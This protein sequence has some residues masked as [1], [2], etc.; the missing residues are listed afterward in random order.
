MRLQGRRLREVAE[1]EY[2]GT[3]SNYQG[4]SFRA[5]TLAFFFA[6]SVLSVEREEEGN[7]WLRQHEDRVS[8]HGFLVALVRAHRCEADKENGVD[9]KRKRKRKR[10]LQSGFNETSW[11]SVKPVSRVL[12][13]RHV[14]SPLSCEELA[15]EG[16]A[17]RSVDLRLSL[18]LII[19]SFALTVMH[20]WSRDRWHWLFRLIRDHAYVC[21]RVWPIESSVC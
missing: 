5:S 2:Y 18:S 12:S 3:R 6:Y 17:E 15:R 21:V 9:T 20:I 7:P 1:C 19:L 16:R 14:V 13:V 10:R 4:L 8:Y 11:G